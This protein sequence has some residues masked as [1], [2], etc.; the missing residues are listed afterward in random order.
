[1][2]PIQAQ[3]QQTALAVGII[4][5]GSL[6]IGGGLA[7]T[8]ADA[9]YSVWY[10]FV[11]ALIILFL[12]FWRLM[13]IEEKVRQFHQTYTKIQK[14]VPDNVE[15][16]ESLWEAFPPAP[17]GMQDRVHG[18]HSVSFSC[19]LCGQEHIAQVAH[20][21]P[22]FDQ[23]VTVQ[24]GCPNTGQVLTVNLNVPEEM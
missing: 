17:S 14:S 20:G 21:T 2:N 19:P 18:D 8:F 16:L 22:I 12:C 5:S 4:I 6:L 9:G 24:V 10:L 13:K 15:E 23:Q 7:T 11:P 3:K 1:M